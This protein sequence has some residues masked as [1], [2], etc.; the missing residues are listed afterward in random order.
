MTF[1][2]N[3][4][5]LQKMALCFPAETGISLQGGNDYEIFNDPR[6]I[7]F[8]VYSP[9]HTARLCR[10][11]FFD[12][13]PQI[14]SC[15][16]SCPTNPSELDHNRVLTGACLWNNERHNY[17]SLHIINIKLNINKAEVFWLSMFAKL[18]NFIIFQKDR[19]SVSYKVLCQKLGLI[20]VICSMKP[21]RKQ[22]LY[23]I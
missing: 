20:S 21:E 3:H 1:I 9:Q 10:E 4:V 12:A 8:T 5:R 6:T 22:N 19:D 23:E 15:P 16:D 13:S 7:G 11:L 17:W 14:F 2:T 18:H